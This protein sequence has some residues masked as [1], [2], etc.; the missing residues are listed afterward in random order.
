MCCVLSHV[1]LTRIHALGFCYRSTH[2]HTRALTAIRGAFETLLLSCQRNTPTDRLGC[3]TR[4]A[5]RP[6]MPDT[7][8][9]AT[10][11]PPA[12]HW[13][14]LRASEAPILAP[15]WRGIGNIF[16]F[17]DRHPCPLTAPSLD[18]GE[19]FGGCRPKLSATFPHRK[20]PGP[21][22]AFT[23]LQYIPL[24]YR[25]GVSGKRPQGTPFGCPHH[26]QGG[27]RI[28]RHRYGTQPQGK[29]KNYG[30]GSNPSTQDKRQPDSNHNH[31]PAV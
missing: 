1:V 25:Q 3:P 15:C 13:L 30:G 2:G 19:P 11:A 31:C 21:P 8:M 24:A 9:D 6:A 14:A 22:F 10:I 27:G 18:P 29:P 4:R 23:Y 26:T 12:C 20:A 5:G 7:A 16:L 17:T 28:L